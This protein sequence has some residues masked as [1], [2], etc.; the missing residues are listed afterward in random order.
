MAYW[1]SKL[2]EPLKDPFT[3]T[4]GIPEKVRFV[5]FAFCRPSTMPAQERLTAIIDPK[6]T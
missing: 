1:G 5:S 2:K 6:R 3:G 4:L